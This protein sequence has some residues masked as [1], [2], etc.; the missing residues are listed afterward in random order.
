MR[1]SYVHHQIR[2]FGEQFLSRTFDQNDVALFVVLARDY[3]NQ[4][5]IIRELG[6]FLAHPK[7][8]DRGIVLKAIDSAAQEFDAY[9]ENEKNSK[10]LNI[11]NL[12]MFSGLGPH[13]EIIRDLMHVFSSFSVEVKPIERED[14]GYRE[15]VFCLIFL[16][17]NF[18]LKWRNEHLVMEVVYGHSLTLQVRVMSGKYH[19]H[20][21]LLP[22]LTL[23]NVWPS[24][25]GGALFESHTLEG[26]IAR[27]FHEGTLCAIKFSK[28]LATS[29]Y[30]LSS[31]ERGEIWP[32][33]A[34]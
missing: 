27:R 30:E 34:G 8:K 22:V 7:E 11:K 15:F 16:L 2:R 25:C 3:S 31:F 29:T 33:E 21:V 10:E 6:D 14:K 17:G 19:N 5:S 20:Y 23:L 13:S 24:Y 12:P 26:Y 28:D 9:L 18:R 1:N 32:V 4:G